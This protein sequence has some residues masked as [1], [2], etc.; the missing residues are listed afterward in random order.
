LD[1]NASTNHYITKSRS[2]IPTIIPDIC[3]Y[4]TVTMLG[5]KSPKQ[6][7]K[8]EIKVNNTRE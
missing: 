8:G 3:V 7:K 2:V 6:R 1:K 5:T 4:K